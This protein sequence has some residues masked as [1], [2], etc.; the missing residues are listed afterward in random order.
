MNMDGTCTALA[1]AQAELQALRVRDALALFA[2]AERQGLDCDVCAAGCWHCH[3]LL[4][5][6]ESAWKQSDAIMARGNPDPH[7]F[8]DGAPLHGKRVLIRCLHGLGDTI[9]FIRYVPPLRRIAASVTIE[10]QP[11]LKGL[12]A[13]SDLAD[14]VI[15]WTDTEPAW[16]SQVEVMELPRIFRTR[17]DT[18]PCSVP[19]LQ[20]DRRRALPE[21]GDTHRVGVVW[22]S[23]VFNPARSIPIQ[24][25]S[26]IFEIPNV[27]FYALQC[28]PEHEE[29]APWQPKVHDLHNRLITVQDTAAIL[30]DL[31]LLITVDTMAA[32]LAG[33]LAI[34]VWTL[35][36]YECDWR[37]MLEREDSPWYP[38]MRLF[39]QPAPGDWS[40]V[41]SRLK[42]ALSEF[43]SKQRPMRRQSPD[44]TSP[45]LQER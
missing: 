21:G 6:F 4:G 19:Y 27:C 33:A 7:R 25:L 24:E 17:L 35:L 43:T 12:L 32:H 14:G 11:K 8:W 13:E 23:S 1:K 31:D 18:I 38:S 45:L 30:C 26:Q 15:T 44:F 36:P 29:I 20:V 28:G 39:R 42:Q 40:A 34:P 41:V 3:M 2:A 9:Q 10:A 16:D 37:W 22:C 5:E